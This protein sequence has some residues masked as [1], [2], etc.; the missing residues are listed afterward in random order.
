VALLGFGVNADVP[1]DVIL[2]VDDEPTV[3]QLVAFI[4]QQEN[5]IVLASWMRN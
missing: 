1:Q 3:R 2:L 5:F 4:L